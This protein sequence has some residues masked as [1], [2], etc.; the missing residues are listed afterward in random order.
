[1]A[2]R[3]AWRRWCPPSRSGTST[4]RRWAWPASSSSRSATCGASG[5]RGRIFSIPTYFFLASLLALLGAGAWRAVTGAIVPVVPGGS[6]TPSGV[7]AL[8]TFL[9]LRAFANGCTAMTGV[10]AVSNGVPA[11]KPPEEKN[12]ADTLLIMAGLCVTLFMGVTLL[13]GA[14]RVVPLVE[15]APGYETVVSQLARGVFGGRGALY[16]GVQAATPLILTLAATP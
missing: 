10:E 4:A 3:P 1:S 16:Y 6:P 14:Y 13:A 8:S 9:I 2:S 5:S 15:S 12:A 11:F 7:T